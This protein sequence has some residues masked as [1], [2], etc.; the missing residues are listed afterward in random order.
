MAAPIIGVT[1]SS[2]VTPKGVP[3]AF[4]NAAYIRAIERAGGVP[5]LLT[6]YHSPD[7][8]KRFSE[9]IDGLLLTGGGDIDPK[10]FGETPHPKTDLISAERDELE[11][12]RVTRQ[13][14]DEGLPL[15]AICRGLQVVNVALNGTLHQ[16]VPDV[17]G[18]SIAHSQPGARNDRTHDVTIEAGSLLARVSGSEQIRVNSFHHQAI[19]AL[20]DGLRPVAWSD[21]KVIEGVELPGARGFMLAVQWHPE[22]LVENEPAA[23]RL[24]EALV[25][26]A[27]GRRAR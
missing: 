8:L 13:A 23:A 19:N 25:E 14:I 9:Q 1:T 11:L 22:E 2:E 10:H 21:D 16:H 12:E 18:E 20:G 4:V 27:S 5:L 3:R 6:P 15:L 24:F 17:F 26:A 7:A